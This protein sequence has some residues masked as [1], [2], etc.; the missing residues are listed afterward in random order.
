MKDF[1]NMS[2]EE[3]EWWYYAHYFSRHLGLQNLRYKKNRHPERVRTMDEYRAAHRTCPEEQIIQIGTKD[4]HIDPEELKQIVMEQMQWEQEKYPQCVILDWA[5]HLDEATPHIHIRKVW[6]AEEPDG[7]YE[8]FVSQK[9]A[10]E[11]MNVERPDPSKK[12]S[13]YNNAKQTY[14]NDCRQ[15]LEFLCRAHGIELAE[16]RK[17]A[18]QTGLDHLEYKRQQEE[19][20]LKKLQEQTQKADALLQAI[21][22]QAAEEKARMESYSD[23]SPSALRRWFNAIKKA[24]EGMGLSKMDFLIFWTTAEGFRATDEANETPAEQQKQSAEQKPR[25]RKRPAPLRQKM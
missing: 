11:Q 4:D 23:E 17:E 16:G 14:T 6:K 2:F 7:V 5:L 20:R 9:K 3:A 15:H 21:Q 22:E 18:S 1:P 13:R 12:E 8:Y 24:W 25:E 19:Q 10:L